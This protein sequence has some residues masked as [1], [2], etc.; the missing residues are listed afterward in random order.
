MTSSQPP[1][2]SISSGRVAAIWT[3]TL[4]AFAILSLRLVQLQVVEANTLSEEGRA[5]RTSS[6]PVEAVRGSIKDATGLILA[7]SVQTYHIAVNQQAVKQYRH[8]GSPDEGQSGVI[9]EGAG[10]GS[11]E[12]AA[13]GAQSGAVDDDDE[14]LL[15]VGPVEAARQLAPLL[16]MDPVELGG[17]MVGDDTYAYL[18]KNVDAATYRKI[19]ALDITGIEWEAVMQREYP[20]GSTASQLIGL[21]NAESQGATGLELT[22]DELLTGRDG[23]E[24]YE[25]GPTGEII[26]GGKRTTVEPV[27]GRD[28]HLSLHAD[29]QH[30]VETM[31]NETVTRFGADWGAVA[32]TEVAT[33]RVLVLAD[34]GVKA[35]KDGTTPARS[36]EYPYPPGSV[37]KIPTVAT[38][39]EEGTVTPT[40]VYTVP[41]RLTTAEGEEFTD[42]HEHPTYERTVTGILAESSNTGAIMIGDTV[43]DEARYNMMS[44]LGFGK[45]TGIELPAETPGV[46]TPWQD[47]TQ[48]GRYVTMFGQDYDI[49]ILQ[50]AA[51]MGAI[52]NGGVYMPPRL[53][54]GWSTP[55][56]RTE[57]SDPVQ[58]T[59]AMKAETAAEMLKIMESATDP[60][61][62]TASDVVVPGYRIALKTG[63]GELLNRGTT[64]S[65]VAG[66]IPADAPKLAIAVMIYNPSSGFTSTLSTVPLF[67]KVA[68]L[69]VR[70]L[71]IP[72]SQ[73]EPDLYPIAPGQ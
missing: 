53:V 62:G 67:T 44:N 5:V 35:P 38:A 12:S 19:R 1:R 36:I 24:A 21:V 25:I 55:D 2:K 17:L 22:Q 73:S 20:N 50:E 42:I 6:T 60:E 31:L 47:W 37:G 28:V 39:I 11:G 9:D 4:V 27:A 65:T 59:Q 8:W 70:S 3:V 54:D 34:S 40:T 56:G 45:L 48:R 63:T 71:A 61:H 13:S 14:V 68:D 23:E 58:P 43:S 46:F 52:G 10:A 26:P 66:V 33:G 32:V 51:M 30:G 7:D 41:D 57:Q 29:L 72:A 64:T 49:T 18:K 69:S 15:G 16:Q